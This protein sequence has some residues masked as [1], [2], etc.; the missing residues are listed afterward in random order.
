MKKILFTIF[1]SFFITSAFAQFNENDKALADK[2]F[3]NKDYYEAAY[4]YKKVAMGLNLVAQP[5]VPFRSNGKAP[6]KAQ[7][8][9]RAYIS[10]QLAESYR[11]YENYLEAEGWY[12]KVIDGN[13]TTKY[14]LV[15]LWYG[16]CLRANQ[17]FDE[18]IKQLEQFKTDYKGTGNYTAIADKELANCH[19][20]KEQ[21]QYPALIDVVKMKGLIN[22]DGS[23][24]SLIINSGNRWITSSRMIK[25][26]KKHLNKIYAVKD[27]ANLEMISFKNSD[28]K[29]EVEY[30]TPSIDLTGK[31]MYLTRWYKEGSKTIHAIYLSTLTNNEWATPVKLNTNIN[32]DGF[33][34]LQ[35]FVTSDGKR[36]FFS[37]NKPGGQGGDDIWVSDL[38]ASGNPTNSTNLGNIVNTP[39]DEQAPYYDSA[40]KKLVYSSKGFVGLGGFDF[41]VSYESIDRWSTPKNMGYPMNSAKDDLYYFPDDNNSKKSYLSSDRASDCCLELFEV[42]DKKY[43]LT[44][45][46][47]DC[48]A[49]TPLPGV[50]VSF[51]DSLSKEVLKV[52]T[53][54]NDAKYTFN[55][56]TKRPYNLVL[57]K[58]GYFTKSVPIPSQGEMQND[59]LHSPDICLQA[60]VVNKPIVIKNILYDFNKA[61]LR[62]ESKV[63]LDGVVKIMVDNPKIRIEMSAHT[64]SIGSDA[65]NNKLS[66][67][68]AQACVDY[69]VSKGVS[70]SRIFAKGYGKMRPI[71]PNSL[72]DGKDN[73]DGRQLNR[74]TEF[75]VLKTE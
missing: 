69:I 2:A 28:N 20:A 60:F 29:K 74:R 3:N 36:L 1:I 38:D 15:R 25:D 30:G 39:L 33:N 23:D 54:G 55:V 48:D 16:I 59:T 70:D 62:P 19:F 56:A 61:D 35:P 8:F 42:Y 10:Y 13:N 24:Y 32:V 72:P 53:V 21:Y 50:K 12:F 6:K 47:T 73:P 64:D 22:S 67:A 34:S 17:H 75:T 58:K 14:P 41:F 43:V 18:A 11:L 44:G 63:I 66:Q 52:E 65:Y 40:D 26:D 45:I 57:E 31:R 5:V 9:D 46:V 7:S 27:S 51:V 37:S 4:Y 68:R 71:A 49:H